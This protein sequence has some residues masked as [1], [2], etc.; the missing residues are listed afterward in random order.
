MGLP[1]LDKTPAGLVAA[2]PLPN[3]SMIAHWDNIV[4]SS[5]LEFEAKHRDSNVFFFDTYAFLTDVLANAAQHHFTN[6]TAFCKDYAAP[7]IGW[8]YSSYGCAPIYNYFWYSE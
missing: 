3:N 8:N 1:V 2:H 4:A 5:A 6:T 7:D